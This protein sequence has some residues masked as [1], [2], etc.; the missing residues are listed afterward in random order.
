MYTITSRRKL[1]Y[2]DIRSAIQKAVRR[3]E[4]EDVLYSVAEMDLTGLGNAVFINLIMF[5]Y[6]DVGPAEPYLIV[7]VYNEYL[8]WKK[9]LKDQQIKPSESASSSQA[10]ECLIRAGYMMARAHKSRVVDYAMHN[11]QKSVYLNLTIDDALNQFQ[12]ALK[13]KDLE[14]TL[15]RLDTLT[16][17]IVDHD[18]R[19][20]RPFK[21][22][23]VVIRK[24]PTNPTI[25]S[26]LEVM[27]KCFSITLKKCLRF[28][29]IHACFLVI[30]DDY[31][32]REIPKLTS[33]NLVN[34]V[35]TYYA[36][37][38]NHD[39]MKDYVYDKHTAKGKKMGRGTQ[40]FILEGSKVVNLGYPE[41]YKDKFIQVRKH[42]T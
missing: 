20:V 40:H 21:K 19:K 28:P 5:C 31:Q 42:K 33:E 12:E 11:F 26:I 1:G 14:M 6:E 22:I 3:C 23:W 35:E 4:V 9:I 2:F 32:I 38:F 7:E 36:E 8:K 17:M 29:L 30:Q 24:Q 15:D 25:S 37:D 27:E 13:S 34:L 16:R 39:V 10:K 41:M 18:G